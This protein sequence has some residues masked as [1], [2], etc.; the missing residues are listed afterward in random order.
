MVMGALMVLVGRYLNMQRR[1]FWLA[2]QIL[3]LCWMKLVFGDATEMGGFTLDKGPEV[4]LV[5][6]FFWISI[7]NSSD[8][9]EAATKLSISNI[10]F[11][12]GSL[13]TK[14]STLI[15][16]SLQYLQIQFYAFLNAWVQYQ[17][18]GGGF[19]RGWRFVN[20]RGIW[21]REQVQLGWGYTLMIT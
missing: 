15:L 3:S 20:W 4:S 2:K 19:N 17:Q 7:F 6:E 8:S 14:P 12:S 11:S 10:F 5:P 18:G 9:V 13:N 1:V 21:C 16:L